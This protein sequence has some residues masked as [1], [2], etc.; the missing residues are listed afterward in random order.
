MVKALTALFVTL[1]IGIAGISFGD[2]CLNGYPEI[3]CV[4]SVAVMGAFV[5]Y[6]NDKRK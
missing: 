5:I 3:G 1:V 2:A 4:A 6:F